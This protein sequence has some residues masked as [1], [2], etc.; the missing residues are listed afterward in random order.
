VPESP[1][2]HMPDSQ[3]IFQDIFFY[4]ALRIRL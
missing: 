2:A 4:S 3:D 1:T